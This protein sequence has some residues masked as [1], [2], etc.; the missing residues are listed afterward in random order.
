MIRLRRLAL[1]GGRIAARSSFSAH[2]LGTV[3]G[4]T[5]QNTAEITYSVGAATLSTTSNTTTIT[6]AEILDVAVTLN[7]ATVIGDTRRDSTRA[8]VHGHEHG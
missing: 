8:R 5:I 4:T 3:A 2:A 6:V 7:T 1:A